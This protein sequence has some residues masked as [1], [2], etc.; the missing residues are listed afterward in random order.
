MS[1]VGLL[2]LENAHRN[3]VMLV[4]VGFMVEGNM[5]RRSDTGATFTVTNGMIVRSL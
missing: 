1:F 5:Q 2:Y 4:A 3:P